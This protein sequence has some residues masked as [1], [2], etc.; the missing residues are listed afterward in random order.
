MHKS[1]NIANFTHYCGLNV[2]NQ[3]ESNDLECDVAYNILVF[4]TPNSGLDV[5][6]CELQNTMVSCAGK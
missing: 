3:I 2:L 1:S 6:S 4:W 5:D